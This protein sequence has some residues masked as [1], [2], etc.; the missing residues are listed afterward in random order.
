VSVIFDG[1]TH[2]GEA[3][4]IVL[5]YV[6]DELTIHQVLIRFRLLFKSYNG[7]ELANV[8]STTL[9]NEFHV[10]LVEHA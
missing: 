3:L 1:T 6:T 8:I 5:R 7:E 10:N 4:C 9:M 2:N